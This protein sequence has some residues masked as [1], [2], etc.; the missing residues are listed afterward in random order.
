MESNYPE[1]DLLITGGNYPPSEFA[2][3]IANIA[4]FVWFIGIA[5]LLGGSQIFKFLGM[6]EPAVFKEMANN[7]MTCFIVLFVINSIGASQLSTGAF[8][9]YL[10]DVEIFSKLSAG[11][12]PSPNDIQAA[13]S[14]HGLL[15]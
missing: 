12:L 8:E 4:S 7:K 1:Y 3:F 11:R 14:K 5:F 6:P 9:M 13:L 2:K 10:D 15:S